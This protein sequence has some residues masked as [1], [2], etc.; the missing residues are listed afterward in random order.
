M[1]TIST[2]Q[3]LRDAVN[4]K[5]GRAAEC[6]YELYQAEQPA[7]NRFTNPQG[8]VVDF[9]QAAHGVIPVLKTFADERQQR[10]D[11]ENWRD[12]WGARFSDVALA[13]WLKMTD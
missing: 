3:A 13:L 2:P 8:S 12:S 9:L 6:R 5:L 7:W 11:F 10:G 4:Q 1:A